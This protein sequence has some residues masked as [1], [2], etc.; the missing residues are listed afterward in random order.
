[1]VKAPFRAR[2]CIAAWP[3]VGIDRED[4]RPVRW[5]DLDQQAPEAIL[6]DAA[7]C[8]RLVKASVRPSELGLK[9]ECGD[10]SDRPLAHSVA[11]C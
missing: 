5:P 6:V 3:H 8:E 2:L 9:A 7:K 11:Q 1:V 4:E 10:R